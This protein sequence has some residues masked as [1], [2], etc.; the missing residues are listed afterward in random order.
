MYEK[1]LKESEA[2]LKT[3]FNTVADAIITI[4]ESSSIKAVNPAVK[5]IFGY[6]S[7]ELL[8]QPFDLLIPEP[9]YNDSKLYSK[10]L[11]ESDKSS[12]GNY[13][14]KG[15][16]V[17]AKK[18]DGTLFPV[19][20]SFG[21]S[22]LEGK[23]LFTG[24]IRDITRLKKAEESLLEYAFFSEFNPGPVLQTDEK[25]N[26]LLANPAA[27]ELF[28]GKDIIG[29]NMLSFFPKSIN[30]IY[31]ADNNIEYYKSEMNISEKIYLFTLRKFVESNKIFIY[32]TDITERKLI[33]NDLQKAMKVADIANRAKSEFLA[34]M[35]HEIRTPMN[36]VLGM[37][38]LCLQ[39]ELTNKQREYVQK[40]YES[41][42]SL[43]GIL[44]DILD[45][46]K[47][48]AGKLEVESVEFQLTNVLDRL[49]DMISLKA[50][51]KQLELIISRDT[52]V[53]E[54][55]KGDPLRL[56]QVLLNITNNAIKFT[57]KGEIKISVALKEKTEFGIILE[58]IVSDTGIGLTSHQIDRLFKAFTQADSS[59]TRKFGGTGLGL[60]IS[61][62]L[63]DL[64]GGLLRVESEPGKGSSFIFTVS[65]KNAAHKIDKSNNSFKYSE[66]N[67]L[68]VD[69]NDN[70]RHVIC[71]MLKSL[72]LKVIDVSSGIQ[73][74]EF[75][76]SIQGEKNKEFD[77]IFMDWKM[78]NMNGSETAEYI[79]KNLTFTKKPKIIM[80]TAFGFDE[81]MDN[82]FYTS[83]FIDSYLYK[84][85]NV[86][87]LEKII[88]KN[89]TLDIDK[90]NNFINEKTSIKKLKKIFSKL[91]ILLVDDNDMNM[92]VSSE[93]LKNVGI[94]V[95]E[96]RDGSLGVQMLMENKFNY[97]AILMDIQMPV[98]DG[99]EATEMIRSNPLGKDIP[100]IAMTADAM[101]GI[102]EK[103]L[104]VGMNDYIS[105]PVNPEELLAKIAKWVTN[106]SDDYLEDYVKDKFRK[107]GYDM[108]S[109]WPVLY[110]ISK[111][112]SSNRTS[113][114]KK[115]FKELLH[116]FNE[117]HYDDLELIKNSIDSNNYKDRHFLIHT[118]KGVVGNLGAELLFFKVSELEKAVNLKNTEL[119]ENLFFEVSEE[120]SKVI[121]SIKSYLKIDN[122]ISV[123][124]R[125]LKEN[126]DPENYYKKLKLLLQ[127]NDT[128]AVQL[129]K[130]LLVDVQQSDLK[131]HLN[132]LIKMVVQY[133]FD[134]A[135]N[136]LERYMKKLF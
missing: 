122:T 19:E 35:S 110:G 71:K 14:S 100:I 34:N 89:S 107:A 45:F 126:I 4:D 43:L 30:K 133:D 5:A 91:H 115:L 83:E 136:Y 99:Y 56:G 13:L 74:G 118:Y 21:L 93:L 10:Y 129:V 88:L 78:P 121:N 7:H 124:K 101:T 60:A 70:A 63:I 2:F 38:H 59:M 42:R 54:Y 82:S 84:P 53:P 66:L 130:E 33:E 119:M 106:D 98:V 28:P 64:M 79:N 12:T 20:V 135:L 95:D 68:V 15:K 92:Q 127:D 97:D 18:R 61:R 31:N 81:D 117:N 131:E 36:A 49:V 51:E 67:A 62:Q 32:G 16:R 22:E 111:E 116:K 104:K 69:D 73:A 57:Q 50:R 55:L 120:T 72:G 108:V 65:F 90:N 48:E 3:I 58:F 27:A 11:S 52:E 44:N 29:L 37:S 128:E 134:E 47:I 24:L 109:D 103:C 25:G 123:E 76:K 94:T 125:I 96:A 77:L 26:V 85:F 40:I 102:R 113:G 41:G 46:S 1:N 80:T 86:E 105:K 132:K 39:T 23:F 114:N 112:L 75:L 6:E 8:G 17:E 87:K 9:Y